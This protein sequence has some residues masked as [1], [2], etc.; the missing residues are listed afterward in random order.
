MT[1]RGILGKIGL[2]FAVLVIVSVTAW[3]YIFN[4]YQTEP[5]ARAIEQGR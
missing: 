5:R 4:A 2:W 1:L 3:L